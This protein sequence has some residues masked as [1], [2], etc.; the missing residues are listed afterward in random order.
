MGLRAR[1]YVFQGG[2][3]NDW[4]SFLNQVVRMKPKAI[5]HINGFYFP[6]PTVDQMV[7]TK[8]LIDHVG[9]DSA[10]GFSVNMIFPETCASQHCGFA[11]PI[12]K[13]GSLS[14]V[15]YVKLVTEVAP[16]YEEIQSLHEKIV[17]LTTD[18]Y[19]A[20][21]YIVPSEVWGKQFISGLDPCFDSGSTPF[22]EEKIERGEVIATDGGGWQCNKNC[23]LLPE[24]MCTSYEGSKRAQ[25]DKMHSTPGIGQ[26]I[27]ATVVVQRKFS[28][29]N[30]LG[31]VEQE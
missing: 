31:H 20:T 26:R 14:I 25:H 29:P 19:E 9:K 6:C 13:E 30:V 5:I 7:L 22:I 28:V 4:P 17:E 18:Y 21:K 16:N 8:D 2:P 24:N 11:S 3:H 15:L 23:C 1:H 10:S 12:E 27:Q